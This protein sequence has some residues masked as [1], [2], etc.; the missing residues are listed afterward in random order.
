MKATT[1]ALLALAWLG[2]TLGFA[3]FVITDVRTATTA[4]VRVECDVVCKCDG[5][6]R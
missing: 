2:L 5:G 3:W 6:A 1:A 4:V